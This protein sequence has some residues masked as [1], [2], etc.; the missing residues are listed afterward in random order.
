MIL[1]LPA[2]LV[3]AQQIDQP[4]RG[5]RDQPSKRT[6]RQALNR[7]LAARRQQALLNSIFGEVEMAV[8]ADQR[9]EDLRRQP[10]QEILDA[11]SGHCERSRSRVRQVFV[12]RPNVR[13]RPRADVLWCGAA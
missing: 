4:S 8:A 1:P 7:P 2:R 3:A 6:L 9:T 11:G 10:T 12:D 5:N 13:V